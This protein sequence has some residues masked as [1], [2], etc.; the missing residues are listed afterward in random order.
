MKEKT[1]M[2]HY[3]MKIYDTWKLCRSCGFGMSADESQVLREAASE[4]FRDTTEISYP[5]I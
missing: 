1:M 3:M 5:S 4:Q 2:M